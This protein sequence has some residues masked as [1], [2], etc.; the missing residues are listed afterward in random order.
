MAMMS[1]EQQCV[2]CQEPLKRRPPTSTEVAE[3]DE[4]LLQAWTRFRETNDPSVPL[5]DA[6]LTYLADRPSD[7]DTSPF[8]ICAAHPD[9]HVVCV[10]P[11]ALQLLMQSHL[12]NCPICRGRLRPLAALVQREARSHAIALAYRHQMQHARELISATAVQQLDAVHTEVEKAQHN[13]IYWSARASCGTSPARRSRHA[14]ATGIYGAPTAFNVQVRFEAHDP[15]RDK[16]RLVQRVEWRR[17][18]PPGAA[19]VITGVDSLEGP[20]PRLMRDDDL[21]FLAD[22]FLGLQLDRL[23]TASSR[24]DGSGGRVSDDAVQRQLRTAS[25]TI[26]QEAVFTLR[27]DGFDGALRR[28]ENWWDGD[29]RRRVESDS[30]MAPVDDDI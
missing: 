17:Q 18:D 22:R 2:I 20:W 27:D 13:S 29:R 23:D 1:R 3:S 19:S 12:V 7:V 6:I 16:S 21:I 11:C 14:A 4:R 9:A 30:A 24:A 28:F 15:P 26:Q 25:L 5:S 10:V 8:A